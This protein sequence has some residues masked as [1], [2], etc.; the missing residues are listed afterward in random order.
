MEILIICGVAFFMT[1]GVVRDVAD[2]IAVAK[3]RHELPSTE[4]WKAHNPGKSPAPGIRGYLGRL[5]TNSVEDWADASSSR[6]RRRKKW[7]HKDEKRR[8][9]A[10]IAKR[11]AR[12]EKAAARKEK[13]AKRRGVVWDKTKNAAAKAK[14]AATT[15]HEDKKAGKQNQAVDD[16]TPDA[17]VL[18]FKPRPAPTEGK[19]PLVTATTINPEITNLTEAIAYPHAMGTAMKD[20]KVKTDSR[21]A[22]LIATASVQEAALAQVEVAI[23]SLRKL[24]VEGKPI[25]GLELAREELKRAALK[26]RA[27]AAAVTE[28]GEAAGTADSAF[29][30]VANIFRKQTGIAEQV[31]AAKASGNRAGKREMYENA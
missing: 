22:E 24:G 2:S 28:A 23:A 20:L 14:D 15:R 17:E 3:G 29:T 16:A 13:W 5:V 12:L 7:R 27:A 9:D 18:E 4:R 10:Y 19:E 8:T 26:Y 1:R 31:Q 6:Y 11:T 30:K 21:A 25:A